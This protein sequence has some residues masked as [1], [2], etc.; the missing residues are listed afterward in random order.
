MDKTIEILL[1]AMVG[2][3]AAVVVVAMMT[4]QTDKFKDTLS[5]ET[6]G[7]QCTLW[8][9]QYQADACPEGEEET[10]P[11]EVSQEFSEDKMSKIEDSC[12]GYQDWSNE[13]NCE[14]SS[15]GESESE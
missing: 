5:G 7:A 15:E 3:I 4:G 2:I 1:V 10:T 14:D 12:P 9:S 11:D 6:E 13:V 8:K